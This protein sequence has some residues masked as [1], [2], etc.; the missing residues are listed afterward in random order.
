MR[1]AFGV[2]ISNESDQA[3]TMKLL[4]PIAS[5]SLLLPGLITAE[6]KKD[7]PSLPSQVFS[8]YEPEAPKSVT[9]ESMAKSA[10]AFLESLNDERKKEAALP[11]DSDEKYRWTNVPPRG[12]QGGVRMGDLNADQLKLALDLLNTVLSPQGYFKARNIPLAAGYQP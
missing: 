3:A 5:V 7:Y 9:A 1:R 6:D 4:L 10:Q 2:Y 11:F 8:N 12:P